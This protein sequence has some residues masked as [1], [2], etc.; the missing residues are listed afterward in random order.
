MYPRLFCFATQKLCSDDYITFMYE[1]QDPTGRLIV[2]LPMTLKHYGRVNCLFIDGKCVE[3]YKT[4]GEATRH[5]RA[6][7]DGVGFDPSVSAAEIKRDF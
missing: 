2:V 1:L 3:Q 5:A 6:L 7:A 4:F